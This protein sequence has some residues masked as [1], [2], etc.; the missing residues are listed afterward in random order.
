M[1]IKIWVKI[2]SA[3]YLGSLSDVTTPLSE[4]MLTSILW[5]SV[6]FTWEQFHS[7]F[8]KHINKITAI[9]PRGHWIKDTSHVKLIAIHFGEV[10]TTVNAPE[11]ENTSKARVSRTD[12]NRWVIRAY[13]ISTVWWRHKMEM[14][15]AL[16]T[17]C[18][19]DPPITVEVVVIE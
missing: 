12:M 6:A 14:L 13:L 19:R 4:P 15:S 3:N 1:A 16:L 7:E 9:S 10:N 17:F 5:G 2:L 8:S 11:S 18:D